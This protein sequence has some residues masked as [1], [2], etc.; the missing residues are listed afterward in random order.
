MQISDFF[1]VFNLSAVIS[2]AVLLCAEIHSLPSFIVL[3]KVGN[4]VTVL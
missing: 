3:S 1:E 4:K 2:S